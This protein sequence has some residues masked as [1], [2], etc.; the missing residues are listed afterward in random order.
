[1]SRGARRSSEG[2]RGDREEKM[3]GADTLG[4][5]GR[6]GVEADCRTLGLESSGETSSFQAGL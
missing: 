4:G 3:R 1:M 6:E 2:K 5:G